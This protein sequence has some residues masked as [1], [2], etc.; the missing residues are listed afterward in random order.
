MGVPNGMRLNR[1]E[2]L[3][4][5]DRCLSAEGVELR[6]LDQLSALRPVWD[7]TLHASGIR[8]RNAMNWLQ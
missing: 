4:A 5:L 1:M 3:A 7:S 6:S 2:A 8:L